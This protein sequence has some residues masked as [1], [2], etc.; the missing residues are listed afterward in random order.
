MS[1]KKTHSLK[2]LSNQRQA[3]VKQIY[4][5]FIKKSVL[6]KLGTT[7]SELKK[8]H[9]QERIF[10]LALQH[11]TA[12]KKAICTAFDLTIEAQCREKRRLEKRDILVQTYKRHIC[13]FTGDPAH[14]LT[15]D[16]SKFNNVL[17]NFKL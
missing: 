16:P 13:K 17:H 14:Y 7:Y 6:Q 15:T 1:Y 3:Q 5:Y 2:K 10:F 11:V 9:S 8:T 12:T 4:I